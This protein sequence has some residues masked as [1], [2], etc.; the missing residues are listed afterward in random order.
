MSLPYQLI[1]DSAD[2]VAGSHAGRAYSDIIYNAT[3]AANTATAL[4]V[5]GGAPMGMPGKT[6]NTYI[7]VFS[8]KPN[9]AFWVAVN[10]TSAI[11]AGA[12]FS[13]AT[14]ELNPP[15]YAVNYGDTISFFCV[16][17]GDVSVAFYAI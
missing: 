13:K 3:I 9:T 12:S 4:T 14:S 2:H 11:P 17:G 10:G 8:Y 7:A 16:A 5:P 1:K 6:I 15:A